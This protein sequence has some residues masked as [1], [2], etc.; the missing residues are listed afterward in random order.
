MRHVVDDVESRY[1]STTSPHPSFEVPTSV[2]VMALSSHHVA[3][4]M[5]QQRPAISMMLTSSQQS[6]A[7]SGRGGGASQPSVLTV[8]DAQLGG[9]T[10]A[11]QQPLAQLARVVGECSYMDVQQGVVQSIHSLHANTAQ[12]SQSDATRQSA[13]RPRDDATS[14][15]S[16]S[17]TT[18]SQDVV[19]LDD[20]CA[21][22][23][24]RGLGPRRAERPS[25]RA[26]SRPSGA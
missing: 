23:F 16:T 10:V 9:A 13:A 2:A 17:Q 5:A 11:Q 20:H 15:A 24:S 6:H 25:T 26:W 1:S 19:L 8:P 12:T 18:T 7:S 4:S 22:C 21:S 3:M 14:H